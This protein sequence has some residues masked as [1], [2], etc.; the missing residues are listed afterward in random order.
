MEQTPLEIKQLR[1]RFLKDY[2]LPIQIVHS[3]Y[4]EERL[5]LAESNYNAKIR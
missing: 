5:E 2:D 3:P 1:K 4:F